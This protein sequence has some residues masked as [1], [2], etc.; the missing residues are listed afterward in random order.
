MHGDHEQMLGGLITAH[1]LAALEDLPALIAGYAGLTGF[2][3][4]VLYVADLQNQFLVPLPGQ[5]DAGG[6]P[7]GPIRVDTT[8]A[9]RAFRSLE[10]IQARHTG[11][12]PSPTL[13]GQGPWRLWVP[14][15]D[16]TEHIG[17]LVLT[18]ASDDEATRRQAAR[19]A[20]LVALILSSKRAT[21]DTYARLVRT[22]PMQLSAEVLWTLLPVRT[23]ATE[24]VVVTAALEPAYLVGG[25]AFDYALVG[26][27]LYLSIFDAMGHD[28]AA[29][30]T[31]TIAMGACRNNRRQGA[32]L[33]A[34]SEAIDAAIAEQFGGTRFATGILGRLD[35]RTGL[36]TWVNR[37]HHPPLVLRGGHVVATLQ[38]EPN[39]PM[40]FGMAALRQ[41]SHYQ[42]EPGDRLL[43][44]TDGVIE[45]R[46]PA[47]QVF[48]LE[49]FADFVIRREADGVSAPETLRR[50]IQTLLEHQRDHLDDDATV[51][52]VEW[53][54][55]RHRQ[56]LL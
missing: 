53:H 39:P 7:L 56:L 29:G 50:L 27:T 49:R 18:A 44:Y 38:V 20:S 4:P 12:G 33:L 52:L 36:L 55:Q 15:L 24:R 17:V 32:D 19:L 1:H 14:L 16:G 26:D 10:I 11:C 8:M 48:G 28:T 40:G 9:G 3:E 25:D 42:L 23:F 13:P 43:F 46:N 30:L 45:A 2:T 5:C 31:A 47:G 41:P 54:S 6:G 37:G 35:T 34:T 22:R 21:S 51:L